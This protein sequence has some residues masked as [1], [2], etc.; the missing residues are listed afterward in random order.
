MELDI[1]K[2][3]TTW[4]DA[5]A[6]INNN[7]AKVKTALEQGGGGGG[8]IAVDKEMSDTSENAVSNK[9]IK[10]YVD[11]FIPSEFSEEFNNDFT[12]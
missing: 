12:N 9:V 2:Q 5:S 11:S 6:S 4:N 3:N 10:E 8:S 7:F 1:L